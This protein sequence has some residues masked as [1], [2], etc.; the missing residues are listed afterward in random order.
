MITPFLNDFF[1]LIPEIHWI[2]SVVLMLLFSTF[3]TSKVRLVL[4]TNLGYLALFLILLF[5]FLI[6]NVPSLEYSLLHYQYTVTSFH[7]VFKLIFLFFLCLCL[8]FSLDYFFFERVFFVEYYFLV[9]LFSVS[10]MFL[11]SANDFILF[12]FTI[13]LQALILYT[14]AALKRYTVFSTE[15]AL[16]YFVLG[17]LSS[18]LLLFG[19][20]LFYG[21]FGTFNFYDLKFIFLKWAGV[22]FFYGII[23]AMLFI[24]SALFF[25]LSAAPFHIWAPDV[26]EGAPT[27]IVLFFATLPKLV[28]FIF[29][30]R[31]FLIV[32]YDFAFVWYLSF[33]FVGLLS[34]FWGTL[35]A[36]N[37][38]N[39]KRLY[40]Y[41]AVTNIG[42]LCSILAYA[43]YDSFVALFNYLL[44]YILS[45]ISLFALIVLFRKATTG[46]KIKF[47][48][49]YRLYASYSFTL[50][51]LI[52]LLFF[53][54][55]GVPPL[56]GFFV[57]FFL[58]RSIFSSDFLLA[59]AF[60][61]IL[62]LSVV[63][64]FYYIRVVRFT[65][66]VPVRVPAF[67]LNLS[68]IGTFLFV[69]LI[70]ILVL[71]VFFQSTFYAFLSLLVST[72]FF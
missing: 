44:I 61:L 71:F 5:A 25:K 21:F 1:F 65:F 39:I 3:L 58:F 11:M 69:N 28:I 57:K 30:V 59:S 52:S 32:M 67:F 7:F 60:F 72:L 4:V 15:S 40:A 38:L 42:Y 20:S 63:A 29:S 23:L 18:G 36:I 33:F 9:G 66:F 6:F 70:L 55:A 37:Q 48:V 34:V 27:P 50:G 47:L 54:L 24:F 10:A 41:S 2:S 62:I 17:A 14:L 53:S 26:Y 49:E 68:F 64:A 12:Y 22:R 46:S 56:A 35:A 8:F 45:T 16:K 19:I 31:L 43:T 13:E 51:L